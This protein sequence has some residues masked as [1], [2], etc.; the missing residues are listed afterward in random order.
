M[1]GPSIKPRQADVA[2]LTAAQLDD[3]AHLAVSTAVKKML[4]T[5]GPAAI[6]DRG[7]DLRLVTAIAVLRILRAVELAAH[8]EA[9]QFT[10]DARQLGLTWQRIGDALGLAPEAAGQGV[11]AADVAWGYAT[12]SASVDLW[13]AGL[14][15][16]TWTCPGCQQV[17]EDRGPGGGASPEYTEP[18]HTPTCPRLAAAEVTW[19]ADRSAEG[20]AS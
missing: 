19:E 17:I 20:E 14:S 8:V 3:A 5:A 7:G 2:K 13:S 4:E 1:P 12:G 9:K 15:S 6:A 10:R 16:F 11:T 18:G